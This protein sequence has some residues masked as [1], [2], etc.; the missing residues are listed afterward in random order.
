M[1]VHELTRNRLAPRYINIATTRY[2]E[3]LGPSA[4]ASPKEKREKKKR[5]QC[6]DRRIDENE[7]DPQPLR[8]SENSHHAPSTPKRRVPSNTY[9]KESDD[10]AAAAQTNPRV[11]PG[12]LWG[13]GKRY[14]RRPSGRKGDTRK[15]HRVGVEMTGISPDLK[16][17]TPRT[18]RSA[19]TF[20]P[21]TS[22]RHHGLAIT[23]VASPWPMLRDQPDR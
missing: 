11:S 3:L 21:P 7:D 8:P 5:K 19:P 14:T 15:R 6:R 18:I 22:L 20:L 16:K 4:Q 12:T 1:Q 17:T 2:N 13:V 9:K 10:N 23:S